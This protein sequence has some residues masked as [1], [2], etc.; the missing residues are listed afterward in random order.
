MVTI[1]A[2]RT[3]TLDGTISANGEYGGPLTDMAGGGA[4][5]SIFITC[6]T[7]AGG[8]S[9]V[10]SARGGDATQRDGSNTG[11]GGGG[12]IAVWRDPDRDTHLGVPAQGN[13]G[14]A[15]DGGTNAFA[16]AQFSG[17]KG[18]IYWKNVRAPGTIFEIQ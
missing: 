16:G 11:G 6:G 9:G 12:R 7:F 4:G 14:T 5:G 8:T 1:V 18:T 17:A 13:D 2:L 15:V 10:L 3:L